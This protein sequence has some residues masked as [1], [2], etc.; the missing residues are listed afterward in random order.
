[1]PTQDTPVINSPPKL[2]DQ[3]RDKLRVKHYS[4]RTES[5]YV[6]WIKRFIRH[7]GKR[8]RRH[9]QPKI[10]FRFIA[11]RS[12]PAAPQD[13]ARQVAAAYVHIQSR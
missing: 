4:I 9:E 13:Q 1:M 7:F 12:M 3:V 5:V 2:L 6:D 8:R 10:S 11:M